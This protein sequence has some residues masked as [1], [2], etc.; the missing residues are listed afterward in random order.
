VTSPEPVAR[1]RWERVVDAVGARIVGNGNAEMPCPV[2]GGDNRRG[3]AISVGETAYP[4][5]Y[6]R[7]KCER[8]DGW[9]S[10]AVAA[11]EA[12][13]ARA[14][15]LTPTRRATGRATA[16]P[17]VRAAA[18]PTPNL[19]TERALDAWEEAL[20]RER[21]VRRA[22]GSKW[23]VSDETIAAASLGW[24]EGQERV[25]MPVRGPA[26]DELLTVIYRYVGDH[27]PPGQPKSRV[28]KGTQ[29]SH[30]YAPFGLG[31]VSHV[32]RA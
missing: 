12:L 7:T 27:L 29:G 2:H 3:L 28:H 10:E 22:V 18:L 25:T 6:C 16:D 11:L 24:D 8:T 17:V 9:L 26:T 1:E 23:Q 32:E 30:V 21:V 4:M 31:R 13:G 5:L 19:P 15:D 20:W 14:E